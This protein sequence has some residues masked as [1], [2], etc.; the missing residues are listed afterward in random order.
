MENNFDVKE[1]I[2]KLPKPVQDFVL[3]GEWETRTLQIAQKYN[4]SQTQADDLADEVLFILIGIKTP[5][6]FKKTLVEDLG[7]SEIVTE[8]VESEIDERVFDYGLKI[9]EKKDKPQTQDMKPNEST[10]D[11]TDKAG[12]LST[13]S[14]NLQMV[15]K[16]VNQVSVP[17]YTYGGVQDKK[18]DINSE[19]VQRP[20]PVPRFNASS[21]EETTPSIKPFQPI[22][23]VETLNIIEAKLNKPASSLS[24]ENKQEMPTTKYTVDPYRE[25]LE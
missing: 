13:V 22:K 4:L 25:P 5:E 10:K 3:D 20:V 15:N 24:E 16:K 14:D 17:V 1:Y 19:P 8:Q 21:E 23:K 12:L 6:L 18:P 9:V 7:L 2:G 11:N